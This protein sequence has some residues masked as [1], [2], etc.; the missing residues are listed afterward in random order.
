MSLEKCSKHGTVWDIGCDEC[1]GKAPE[2]DR[3]SETPKIA[4]EVLMAIS[5]SSSADFTRSLEW[6]Q[7]CR[8][9]ARAGLHNDL[10][11][12]KRLFDVLPRILPPKD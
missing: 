9:M 2:S 1:E 11:E 7:W 6:G 5:R 3:G 12:L 10:E 8:N 4:L